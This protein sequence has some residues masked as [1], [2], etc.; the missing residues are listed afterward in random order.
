MIRLSP[1]LLVLMAGLPAGTSA[2]GL[3]PGCRL[4][5]GSL[6]CVPGLT[7]DPQQQIQVL[8]GQINRDVQTEG[9]LEQA[10]EG[11][12]RFELIGEAKEGQLIKAELMLQGGGFEEVHI[13]WY[14][15]NNQGN[16]QLVDNVTEST[17]R[18]GPSDRGEQL[19][20]VLVVRTSD[21]KVQRIS[22]N[23][24]GPVSN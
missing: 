3:L 7:A 14:R 16:W 1:L 24:L 15:R 10:I 18:V 19:M 8:E 22:S 12:K 13:H 4:E 9:H 6:Q 11:L 2:Q 21:G 5:N 23:V 17:Y 20:A